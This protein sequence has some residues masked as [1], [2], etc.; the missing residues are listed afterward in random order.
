MITQYLPRLSFRS[1]AALTLGGLLIAVPLLVTAVIPLPV[2]SVPI[3]D[4]VKGDTENIAF[5]GKA[6][7]SGKVIDDPHFRGPTVLQLV[8]DFSGV[9]GVGVTSGKKYVTEAQAVL[10]RP[11]IAFDPIQA[12]FPYYSSGNFASARTALASFAVS[13]GPPAGIVVTSKVTTPSF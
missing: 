9:T 8:I 1:L 5:S 2:L 13:Y 7:I 12:T 4:V 10:H 3:K 11:L 6:S